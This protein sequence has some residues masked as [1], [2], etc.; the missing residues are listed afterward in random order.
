[1][2]LKTLAANLGRGTLM[3]APD[4]EQ[5]LRTHS[6]PGNIRELRNVLERA[7]LLSD[8]PV[9]GRKDLRF[10]ASLGT[11]SAA[12]DMDLSLRELEQQH[13][14]RILQK[15]QGHVESA[16]KRLGIPRSTLYQKIKQYQISLP[17]P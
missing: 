5:A 7:V 2:L 4:A 11:E 14:Q 12:D 8:Q 15:E 1:L 3:L 17:D 16:A 9:L 13:I 10:D 6:W